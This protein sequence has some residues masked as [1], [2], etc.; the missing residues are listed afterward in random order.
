MG[1]FHIN[2]M[3]LYIV[4]C[5]YLLSLSIK[6]SRSFIIC[7]S[8]LFPLTASWYSIVNDIPLYG[9][10]FFPLHSLVNGHLDSFHFSLWWMKLWTFMYV[11]VYVNTFAFLLGKCLGMRLIS[12]IIFVLKFLRN[13]LWLYYFVVPAALVSPLSSVCFI[14]I[15]MIIIIIIYLVGV[16]VASHWSFHL[17]FPND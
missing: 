7:I 17:H 11:N 10:T 9:N 14:I 16:V 8:N 15:I 12:H 1:T 6:V 13:F 2:G 5:L 3:T 4:F